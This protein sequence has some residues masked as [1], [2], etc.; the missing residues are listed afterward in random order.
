MHCIYRH[1]ELLLVGDLVMSR[2][3]KRQGISTRLKRLNLSGALALSR[4]APFCSAYAGGF[5][6]SHCTGPGHMA[7]TTK[8]KTAMCC[9]YTDDQELS[10][11]RFCPE[12][13]SD[14]IAGII[15][16]PVKRCAVRAA[17]QHG[18]KTC[19]CILFQVVCVIHA[20]GRAVPEPE[21]TTPDRCLLPLLPKCKRS[22]FVS[23]WM[24]HGHFS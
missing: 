3:Q 24:T 8:T 10:G 13:C 11:I 6:T 1:W 23:V 19:V 5:Y 15:L 22:I 4:C 18:N 20:R 12:C 9:L 2:S 7:I 16:W 17:L 14:E 21:V